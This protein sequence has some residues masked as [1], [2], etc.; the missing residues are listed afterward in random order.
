MDLIQNA[1]WR[2]LK[3]KKKVLALLFVFFIILL[4]IEL[5]CLFAVF[6]VLCQF[7]CYND[8]VSG[9]N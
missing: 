1:L 9:E 3:K 4:K 6:T 7:V 2:S 5:F 8:E